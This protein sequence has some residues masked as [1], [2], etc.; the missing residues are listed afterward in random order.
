MQLPFFSQNSQTKQVDSTLPQS[1][2]R[3][4]TLNYQQAIYALMTT[5]DFAF[6][7]LVGSGTTEY[8]NAER[9]A[10]LS[11]I[12]II[13]LC[14]PQIILALGMH[15]HLNKLQKCN[16]YGMSLLGI[17]GSILL[18]VDINKDSELS[19]IGFALLSARLL[20]ARLLSVAD[21]HSDNTSKRNRHLLYESFEGLGEIL[22]VGVLGTLILEKFTKHTM[23]L[24]TGCSALGLATAMFISSI[25]RYHYHDTNGVFSALRGLF[26]VIGITGAIM[27]LSDADNKTAV[28]EIGVW[29]LASCFGAQKSFY[30]FE[31]QP[32]QHA[33][34]Y[35][36]LEYV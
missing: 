36:T 4:R 18:L 24:S 3:L 33:A 10:A 9:L 8:L 27:M 16:Y 34:D 12:P 7:G 32:Q 6:E 5:E 21:M 2:S 22:L 25:L 17:S 28:P 15:S 20:L 35:Q 26:S 14:I 13:A 1:A 31:N 11:T 23:L 30:L 19:V 29:L